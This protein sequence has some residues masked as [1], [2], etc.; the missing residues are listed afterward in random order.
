MDYNFDKF[1]QDSKSSC[2]TKSDFV[3][4]IDREQAAVSKL[5]NVQSSIQKEI[6]LRRLDN[7]KFCTQK[8]AMKFEDTF[9]EDLRKLLD[10]LI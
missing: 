5:N 8:G 1:I 10:N 7:A 4:K 9:N 3:S 2:K 6:Y